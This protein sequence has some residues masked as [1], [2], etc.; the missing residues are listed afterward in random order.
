MSETKTSTTKT[1]KTVAKTPVPAAKKEA[2]IYVG[3]TLRGGVLSRYSVFK[4]GELPPHVKEIADEHKCIKSL[5]VPVSKLAQIEN[6]LL[7]KTSVEAVRFAEA[8]TVFK[9]E[10]E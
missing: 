5:L 10:V 4:H 3:P 8:Q 6:R 7:D 9:K 1:K 2:L